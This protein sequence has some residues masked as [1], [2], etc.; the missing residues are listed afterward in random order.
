VDRV[1]EAV[2]YHAKNMFVVTTPEPICMEVARRRLRQLEARGAKASVRR[3][4]LNRVLQH[5]AT[6]EVEEYEKA[7]SGK[8][9]AVLPNDYGAIQESIAGT[10]SVSLDSLLGKAYLTLAGSL[11]GQEIPLEPPE[12]KFAALKN[13]FSSKKR[14]EPVRVA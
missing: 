8:I 12:E 14:T 3:V 9:A 5:P 7:T 13:L 4:I 11:A 2:S 1:T 6:V 10:S